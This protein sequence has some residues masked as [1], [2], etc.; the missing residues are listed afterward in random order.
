MVKPL[1]YVAGISPYVPGKP[2][3]EL[4][5]ELGISGSIKLASNENPLGPSP[6][7]LAAISEY[8]KDPSELGRYPD[9]SGFYLKNALC[10][11]L[12]AYGVAGGAKLFPEN[13]ILGNGSNELLTIAV[14]TFMTHKDEAVMGA[15]SFV[16][17]SISVNS[18]GGQ[19]IQVPLVEYRHDLA[20][21]AESINENTKIVFI[22]NPNNPTGAANERRDF[23]EFL[24]N[25]PESVL[26]VMDEAYYEYAFDPEYP[27][28]VR[29]F[30]GK[31]EFLVLRTFSKAYGL[32]GLRIGYGIASEGVIAEMNKIREPFNTNALAQYAALH[33]LD[34]K[35]HL[36][37]SI[38]VNAE[39]RDYLYKEFESAGI[40]YVPTQANF[41]YLPLGEDSKKAYDELLKKGVIVRPVGPKEIRVTIGLPEENRRFMDA[42][43]DVFKKI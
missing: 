38:S 3:K 9:A 32:A 30:W 24:D 14:R 12:N 40:N 31:R 13:I 21:M 6:K 26:V 35:D 8:L 15:P 25:I 22:A 29:D 17:Y 39:G 42:F 11:R 7:A 36:D 5:R 33:A 20:K 19:M 18:V 34:D 23:A 2:L 27:Q 16:V 37:R 4:E 1:S 10:D 41:I 28:V 43:R